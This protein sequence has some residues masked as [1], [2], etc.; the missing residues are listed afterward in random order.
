M[1]H[2]ADARGAKGFPN[3]TDNDWLYGGSPQE[4]ETSIAY[5]RQGT[6]PPQAELIGGRRGVE[7][8]AEYV[9]S[10]NKKP[11]NA[12]LAAQGKEKFMTT[13]VACHGADATGNKFIGAPNLTNNM[14]LFGGRKKTIQE[15]IT[16]GRQSMMP[17]HEKL[18]GKDKVHLVAAYVYGLSHPQGQ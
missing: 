4:I 17:A 1:C 18:L 13:C 15:T 16:L 7:M 6:M 9:L 10:L 5:G 8:V 14:W 2:G 12:I 11:H 3:L